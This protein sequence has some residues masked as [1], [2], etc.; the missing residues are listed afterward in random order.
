MIEKEET[1]EIEWLSIRFAVSVIK[2]IFTFVLLPIPTIKHC[3]CPHPLTNLLKENIVYKYMYSLW[4]VFGHERIK[5][6]K[7]VGSRHGERDK[8]GEKLRPATVW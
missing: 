3:P 4:N 2:Q 5:A 1:K 6:V 8:R 7:E